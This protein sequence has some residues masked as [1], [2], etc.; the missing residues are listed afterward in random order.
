[1]SHL[2]RAQRLTEKT[3]VAVHRLAHAMKED[4]RYSDIAALAK[5]FTGAWSESPM[6]VRTLRR[7]A[8]MAQ[9]FRERAQKLPPWQH[10]GCGREMKRLE[11]AAERMTQLADDWE[12][13]LECR[14]VAGALTQTRP[15]YDWVSAG[16]G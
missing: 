5:T 7:I 15:A 14:A 12:L 9:L 10:A 2:S 1:M 3:M 4:W 13:Q 16:T 6:Q 8:K 11:S